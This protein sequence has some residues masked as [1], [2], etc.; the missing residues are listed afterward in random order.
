MWSDDLKVGELTLDMELT[1]FCNAKCPQC[2][3]TNEVNNLNK[4]S[5]LPLQQVSISKFKSWFSPGDI[6]Y[7]SNFHFSGT[8]G[9]PGMCKDLYKIVE[10][11]IDNSWNSTI[12]INTNGGMRNEDFWFNIGAKG[13]KRLKVIFDVDGID[14]EMHSFYRRNVKLSTVLENM[15]S[16][17]QTTA[18]VEVLT[19]LF[20]H[21]QE[22]LEQI[23]DMCRKLGVQH[24]D[25]VEGNNFQDGPVYEFNDENG[26]EQQL[27][28][29]TRQDREQGLERLDRRVRDHRHAR[30]EYIEI[31]CLAEEQKT[32]K[33]HAT[34]LVAPCCYLSTPLEAAAIYRTKQTAN[35][36]ITTVGKDGAEINPLMKEYVD[37]HH[38]FTLGNRS[39]KDIV[40]DPWFNGKLKDSWKQKET[41]AWGC[42]KVCGKACA[43]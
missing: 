42:K 15:A 14:Q 17:L 36:H 31:S 39:I 1:T 26:N 16:V 5:W 4:K 24:F 38:M 7:I 43:A 23:E 10:Y 28:Q 2:S 25:S 12:S 33:V 13:Q 35:R 34:G 6:P 41:A 18:K 27:L 30:D 8:Y 20:R 32:L 22:Y 3:R 19:V 9:D 21:N 40:N 29:I 37:N 11:I